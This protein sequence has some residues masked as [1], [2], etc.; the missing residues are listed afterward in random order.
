[1]QG[2]KDVIRTEGTLWVKGKGKRG[3]MSREPESRK[4]LKDRIPCTREE[5][6]RP[7]KLGGFGEYPIWP[8][9]SISGRISIL[10]EFNE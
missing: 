6:E 4:L 9:R 10:V 1:V 2:K 8:W 5:K 3:R 7:K